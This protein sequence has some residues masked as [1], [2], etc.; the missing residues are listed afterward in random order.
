MHYA[1]P[2]PKITKLCLKKFFFIF[3]KELYPKIFYI[4]QWCLI[5]PTT[6]TLRSLWKFLILSQ[7]EAL[8]DL[9][10]LS[11][12]DKK[13]FLKKFLTSQHG[14][15]PSIKLLIPSYTLGWLLIERRIKNKFIT[16]YDCWFSLPCE[17]SNFNCEINKFTL[18][19]TKRSF[20]YLA[21][22]LIP[23]PRIDQNF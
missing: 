8:V 7:K 13:N 4:L 20:L 17:L 18:I 21:H 3:W 1:I 5:W 10:I 15:W 23:S 22:S 19:S 11:Q 6:T 16:H 2:T 14:S 9:Q 12:K